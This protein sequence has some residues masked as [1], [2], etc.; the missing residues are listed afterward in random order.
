MEVKLTKEPFSRFIFFTLFVK[1][2]IVTVISE[3]KY[4]FPIGLSPSL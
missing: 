4:R 3:L 2:I 1:N